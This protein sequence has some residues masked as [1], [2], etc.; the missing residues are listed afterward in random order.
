MWLQRIPHFF[1]WLKRSVGY[2]WRRFTDYLLANRWQAIGFVFILTFLPILGVFFGILIATFIT[3]RKG[4]FE[5]AIATLATTLPY[6]AIFFMGGKYSGHAVPHVVWAAVGVA[7]LSNVLTWVFAVML[8]RGVVWSN[9]LQIAA[10]A[11]VLAISVIHLIFPDVANWWGMQLQQVLNASDPKQ[12]ALQLE[13]INITKQFATGVMVTGILLNAILQLIVARWWEADIFSPGMLRKELHNIRLS[14]L[15][16]LLFVFGLVLSYIGN[17]VVMDIL[18]VIYL[19]FCAA[20]LSLIHYIFS[21]MIV[22]PTRWFWL[23]MLYMIVIFSLPVSLV[24]ISALALLDIV[25]DVR[26]RFKKI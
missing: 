22:S 13:T 5:G 26:K 7:V 20:G 12:Q 14:R 24:M 2:L 4:A 15:A 1:N 19:L 23:L 6:A 8:R 9:I 10:L 18:P 17:S 11:G 16:G 25:F 21:T 3:L